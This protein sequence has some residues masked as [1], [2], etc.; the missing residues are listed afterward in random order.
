VANAQFSSL[1]LSK[2]TIPGLNAAFIPLMFGGQGVS[3][4][5]GVQMLHTLMVPPAPSFTADF[6]GDNDVDKEDLAQWFGDFGEK[7]LFGEF[8]GGGAI[9]ITWLIL[10][11]VVIG[12]VFKHVP[13]VL[14]PA[15]VPALSVFIFPLG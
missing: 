10:I 13:R 2:L 1:D 12:Y 3:Q 9:T 15:T 4:I 14:F 6:D 8:F 7:S 5:G 11:S